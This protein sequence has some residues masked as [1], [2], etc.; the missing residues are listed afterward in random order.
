MRKHEPE[1]DHL[2]VFW[3][4]IKNFGDDSRPPYILY[5]KSLS[6]T[7]LNQRA[8]NNGNGPIQ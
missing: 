5:L 6:K 8:Q 1:N 7:R 3:S 2:N 4:K